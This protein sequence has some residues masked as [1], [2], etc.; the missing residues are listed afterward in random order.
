MSQVN[1]PAGGNC[2]TSEHP[3]WNANDIHHGF[4]TFGFSSLPGGFRGTN[5]VYGNIG[6]AAIWWSA[7]EFNDAD[8]W[9]RGIYSSSAA[10]G[11]F[12]SSKN[13]GYSVRCI[14]DTDAPALYS[15]DLEVNPSGSGN[16]SGA[17]T[18]EE[19]TQV[20]VTATASEGWEFVQWTGDTEYMDDPLNANATVTMPAQDIFITANFE[21]EDTETEVVDVINPTTG[22][23]WMDRNLGAGRAA[24]SSTDEEAYGD[25]YQWGRGADGHQK[26][27]SGT[28]TTLSGSDTPGHGDFILINDSPWDWRSPQNDNLWQ[29]VNGINNPC[30]EG[31]RLPTEAEL[32]A[33]RLSWDS[34]DAAGA[35][36]SPLKLP[37]AG[38]R[39]SSNGSLGFVGSYGFYWSSTV[40]DIGSRA[41]GFYAPKAYTYRGARADGTTVRCLKD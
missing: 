20:P 35:F 10:V 31:Y 3:R 15:L 33:E 4:D 28:T 16:V 8:A 21:E 1:S 25:L 17:G 5:G 38:Y 29:G 36:A 9:E 12:R 14:R 30:P 41:L 18:Y 2:D 26:R 32:E 40:D 23:T 27:T 24:T 37:M 11:R 7:S 22:K 34:D 19:G 13:Y 6:G 39:R